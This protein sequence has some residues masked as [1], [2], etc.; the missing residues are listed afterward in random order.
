MTEADSNS[1][2]MQL[3]NLRDHFLIAMP[4]LSDPN[5]SN[6]LIYVCEHSKE[7]SMGLVINRPMDV[8]LSHVFE[9]LELDSSTR[10]GEQPLLSGGPVGVE[11][12]F[13]LHTTKEQRWESTMKV[14]ADIS[15]TASRDILADIA[16]GHGPSDA[17]VVLGYAGWEPGQLE[18]EIA[19]NAW[20]TVPASADIVFHTPFAE[21][22]QAAASTLGIDLIHLSGSAGHA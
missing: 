22:A 20:L 18:Q 19:E 6:A 1:K 5:F 16:A 17:V 11:R 2:K 21:R 9:Q 3:G 15:L 7:G 14:S 8:P 13:V 12:G 4:S 10:V